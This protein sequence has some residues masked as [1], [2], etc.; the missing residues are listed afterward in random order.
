MVRVVRSLAL[1]AAGLALAGCGSTT[2]GEADQPTTTAA[3]VT[4]TASC[5]SPAAKAQVSSSQL[6]ALA[7]CDLTGAMLTVDST[8]ATGAAAGA[9][10]PRIGEAVEGSGSQTSGPEGAVLYLANFGPPTGVAGTV[11]SG[12]QTNRTKEYLGAPK[13]IETLRAIER[14]LTRTSS[15]A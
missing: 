1:G 9:T 2:A 8:K 3:N 10:I 5:P 7:S 6:T 4:A 12:P 11:T 15:T 14:S 13:A